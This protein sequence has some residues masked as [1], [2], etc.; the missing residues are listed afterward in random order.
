MNA[1]ALWIA[2]GLYVAQA[3]VCVCS[4]QLPQTL[5]LSGYVI[6]NLGLIW[7]MQ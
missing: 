2:T 1:A 5:I 6:A 4:G 7:S 3:G